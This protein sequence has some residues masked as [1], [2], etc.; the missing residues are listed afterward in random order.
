MP[1]EPED[2]LWFALKEPLWLMPYPCHGCIR[3]V[4]MFELLKFEPSMSERAN[5]TPPLLTC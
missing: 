2:P 5:L 3:A 1:I 4:F